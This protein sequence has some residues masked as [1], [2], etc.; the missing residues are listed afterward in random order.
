MYQYVDTNMSGFAYTLIWLLFLAIYIIAVIG[1]WKM[2]TKAGKPGWAAIIPLYNW[3]VWIKIIGRP[4]WW[5]W[6]M[7]AALLLSWI[8]LIGW[9]LTVLVAILWLLG[10]LDMARCFGKGV[11]HG[12]LLWLFPFILAP[13]L[14]F[15]SARYVGTRSRY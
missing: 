5:F 8:P 6:A 13:I 2:Y 15:G 4:T 10:C 11:G 3:W 1:L 7:I 14:G 9:L 12:L